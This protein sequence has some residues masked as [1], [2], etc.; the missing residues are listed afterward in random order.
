MI[1]KFYDITYEGYSPSP[2]K[3]KYTNET[4]KEVIECECGT[5]LLKVISDVDITTCDTGNKR[6]SQTFYLALFYYGIE[7]NLMSFSKRLKLALK[8]LRT[9]KNH[10]D[11]MCLTPLEAVKLSEFIRENAVCDDGERLLK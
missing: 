1:R 3:S 6:Y 7:S 9:G 4:E 5:H 11:Q 8:I 2:I 10:D